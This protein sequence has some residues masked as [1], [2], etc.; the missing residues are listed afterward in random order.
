MDGVASLVEVISNMLVSPVF[1]V[2]KVF[3]ET[4]VNGASC[5]T[6]VEL[7]AFCTMYDVWNVVHQAVELFRGVHLGLRTSNFGVSADER[8]CSTFCLITWS[9]PWC[10]V[11][12]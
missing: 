10:Y 4:G 3:F 5:F 6:D 11:V 12:G 8:T 2:R 1:K 9:G 7:S